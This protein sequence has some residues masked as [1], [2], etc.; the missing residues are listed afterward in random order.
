M[1][2]TKSRIIAGVGI[3]IAIF[4]L[5]YAMRRSKKPARALKR[6]DNTDEFLQV[7]GTVR[8]LAGIPQREQLLLY[9]LYK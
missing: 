1:K 7:A 9:G 5:A 6:S 4:G 8:Q 2:Q 3:G